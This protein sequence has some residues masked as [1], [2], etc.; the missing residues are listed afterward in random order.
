MNREDPSIGQF[1]IVIE[2]ENDKQIC[3]RALGAAQVNGSMVLAIDRVS[4]SSSIELDVSEEIAR[5]LAATALGKYGDR[6]FSSL[7]QGDAD[8]QLKELSRSVEGFIDDTLR[9]TL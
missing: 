4:P 1:S 9:N 6:G 2:S 7:T 3:K 5:G 8:K